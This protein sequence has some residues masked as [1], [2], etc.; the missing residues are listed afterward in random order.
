MSQGPSGWDNDSERALTDRGREAASE[1]GAMMRDQGRVPSL[2]MHS[3]ARRA[4]ETW[5]LMAPE[6][7]VEVPA[8]ADDTLYLASPQNLFATIT[9]TPEPLASVLIVG[10]NPGLHELAL[11]LVRHGAP[12]DIAQLRSGYPTGALTE[13]QFGADHWS[14][15]RPETGRLEWIAFPREAYGET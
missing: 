11:V 2:T 6:L 5:R 9:S 15:L 12:G 14:D 10:H 8:I 4:T 3:T 1:I 7:G 13:I